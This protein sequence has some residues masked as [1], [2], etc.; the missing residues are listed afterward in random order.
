MSIRERGLMY[1]VGINDA[2]YITHIKESTGIINKSSGLMIYKTIWRC[3]FYVR[4]CNMLNR[5][6]GKRYQKIQPTYMGCSVIEEWFVFSNFKAWMET[7]DWEGKQLD[8]D[9]LFPGNKVYGPE[10]CCFVDSRTNSFITEIRKSNGKLPIG[11]F[12]R[13]NNRYGAQI[14]IVSVDGVR[15]RKYLGTFETEELAYNAWLSSKIEQAA[16]L[17]KIQ[18]DPR[19]ANALL[20]RYLICDYLYN[21]QD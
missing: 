16:L 10:T 2:S 3:T 19:V 15:K 8:K 7:Q 18:K 13:S 20:N 4:W 21:V 17:A 11:V 5:C 12:H 14:S 1:G 9:I 6:Y